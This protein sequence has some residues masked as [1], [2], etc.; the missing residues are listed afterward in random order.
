MSSATLL[1][2]LNGISV[3]EPTAEQYAAVAEL[4]ERTAV[5]DAELL[6]LRQLLAF[7]PTP[8]PVHKR[9]NRV[10]HGTEAAA[11][12]HDEYGVPLCRSCRRWVYAH[13]VHGTEQACQAHYRDGTSLCEA[14]RDFFAVQHR[15]AK[16]ASGVSCGSPAGYKRH[17]RLGER[18]CTSCRQAE[19][20]REDKRRQ[21]FQARDASTDEQDG[22]DRAPVQAHAGG[23]LGVGETD[24]AC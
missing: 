22:T 14:C 4:L 3:P 21:E 18:I 7:E 11:R 16:Y 8:R 20:R 10:T 17:I 9:R 6:T 24:L 5:D 15:R 19:A 1:A 2:R 12:W 13:E 23:A